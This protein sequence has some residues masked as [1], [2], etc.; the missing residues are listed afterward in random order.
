MGPTIN[1]FYY[2]KQLTGVK[3]ILS[4]GGWTFSTE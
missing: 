1:Q 4:F 3:K 2:F